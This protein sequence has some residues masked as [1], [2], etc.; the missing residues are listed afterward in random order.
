MSS[1]KTEPEF[2]KDFISNAEV[3]YSFKNVTFTTFQDCIRFVKKENTQNKLT[4]S[5]YLTVT[6]GKTRFTINKG[7]ITQFLKIVVSH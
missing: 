7:E 5:E 1:G 6:V 3:E 4:M 2:I